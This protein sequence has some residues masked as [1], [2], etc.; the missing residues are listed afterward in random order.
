MSLMTSV[1]YHIFICI[2]VGIRGGMWPFLGIDFSIVVLDVIIVIGVSYILVTMITI[3][4]KMNA[5]FQKLIL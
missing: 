5:Y 2:L 1:L 4:I 3:R